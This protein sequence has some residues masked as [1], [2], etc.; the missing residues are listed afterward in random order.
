MISTRIK[1]APIWGPPFRLTFCPLFPGGGKQWIH[2]G[3]PA[4]IV[5]LPTAKGGFSGSGK[6]PIPLWEKGGEGRRH[7]MV[8]M[9]WYMFDSPSHY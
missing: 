9:I 8:T 7:K 1:H 3:D 5:G 2:I 6:G 4:E